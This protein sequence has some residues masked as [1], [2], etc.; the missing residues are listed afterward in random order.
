M[1]RCVVNV[2]DVFGLH[3][4]QLVW[5]EHSEHL[6]VLPER[7]LSTGRPFDEDEARARGNRERAAY[8]GELAV[9]PLSGR[10]IH[11]GRTEGDEKL[12]VRVRRL[13]LDSNGS[14]FG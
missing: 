9:V 14:G 10:A 2:S 8:L 5:I 6:P 4:R 3:L 11:R 7:D 1:I 13:V 12:E